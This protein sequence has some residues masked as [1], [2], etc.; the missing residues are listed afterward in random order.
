[1]C[2]LTRVTVKPCWDALD[3]TSLPRVAWVEN[4][5]VSCWSSGF[6]FGVC[7]LYVCPFFFPLSV[8]A[9]YD[10]STSTPVFTGMPWCLSILFLFTCSLGAR[11]LL[12]LLICTMQDAVRSTPVPYG[13][14]VRICISA[15]TPATLP[16]PA[17]V[18][19][20]NENARITMLCE[21]FTSARVPTPSPLLL[22]PASS[23]PALLAR[24]TYI[25]VL[26]PF[27]FILFFS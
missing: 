11:Y 20:W 25:P 26:W 19:R 12:L 18:P 14:A 17:T 4:L 21:C 24:S 8:L 13:S 9:H 23:P 1:V 3:V 27:V 6:L 22:S 15:H 7:Y 2:P 10:E 16:R 5:W